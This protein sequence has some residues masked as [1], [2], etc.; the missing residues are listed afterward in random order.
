MVGNKGPGKQ[1]I[2]LSWV[3]LDVS[4]ITKKKSQKSVYNT[5]NANS[6][7]QNLPIKHLPINFYILNFLHTLLRTYFFRIRASLQVDD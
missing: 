7:I 3:D 2:L 4:T 5:I 6:P 1:S